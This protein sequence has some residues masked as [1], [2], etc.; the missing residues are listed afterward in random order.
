[1]RGNLRILT[2]FLSYFGS[3]WFCPCNILRSDPGRAYENEVVNS[4]LS[5]FRGG[6]D[7]GRGIYATELSRNLM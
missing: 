5:L 1:M 3:A 7:D 2:E 6:R 4:F